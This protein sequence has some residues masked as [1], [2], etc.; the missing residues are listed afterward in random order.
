M[1]SQAGGLPRVGHR[2]RDDGPAAGASGLTRARRRACRP[3]VVSY[4][5]LACRDGPQSVVAAGAVTRASGRTP[6]T[7]AARSC[8]STWT[9]SSPRSR[10][11]AGPSCAAG[12]SWSA[13]SGRA[14]VVSSA[15]YE[16]RRFGVRSAMPTSAGAGALPARGLPAARLRRRTRPP[17]RAVMQIF[18]DVTPLVEPLSLDEAFLDVAGARR[19]FGRPADDRPRGSARRVADEQRLTC[20]V[21]VA[22][23]KFVA[24]LGSTRA[25]PDGLLVVPGRPGARLPA[26]AAGRRAV[27]GG[28]AGR[29]DAAP[30]R[31]DAPSATWPRRRSACCAARSARRRRRTCTSWPGGGTRAGSAPSRSRSRSAPR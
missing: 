27:G 14:G 28:G 6:T 5:G 18:R 10:C 3:V 29:R 23:T 24:K 26:P 30:A 17:P 4:R 21:G 22:P 7:P 15:S 1:A 8:T 2:R 20:S 12:R 25:K 16:A 11:A 9:R 31:P 19:L 13:A